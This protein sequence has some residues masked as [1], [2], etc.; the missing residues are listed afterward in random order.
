[1]S[2]SSV[3]TTS[4]D[5]AK[6]YLAEHA[7]G[8]N[9]VLGEFWHEKREQ[10]QDFPDII[11]GAFD[12]YDLLT[13]DGKK[14]RAGLVCLGHDV[15]RRDDSPRSLVA[16][17]ILRAA[18]SVEILHNAFLIHDDIVDRADLRRNKPTVHRRYA[19]R[20]RPHFATE[21]AALSYGRAVA[22]NFGDKGQ[23]LAQELLVSSGF[24]EG[25]LLAAIRL[26]SKV[27]AET[28]AGQLLD[29]ADVRLADLTE[30]QVLQ[31]HE[32]KTAHYTIMLPLLMGA[33][34]AGAQALVLEAMR[35]FAIPVGI[36]FQVQ[37]DILGLYGDQEILGKPVDSDLKEGKKTLLFVH[38]YAS[39]EG[40]DRAFLD[41]V[42]G[43]PELTDG[44]LDRVRAI[45]RNCGALA[46]SEAMA[47]EMVERG[48]ARIEAVTCEPRWTRVLS[49]L[50]DYLIL[51]RY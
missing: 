9:R 7:A 29:V 51:R 2:R 47:R 17:G 43:N 16:D 12:A 49:G 48:R 18:G 19:E 39:C 26:L 30:E 41:R 24:P 50:A 13:S 5:E 4:L 3:D 25:V 44:D 27:T 10:W 37:D 23:A 15:V 14:I 42:H 34:L 6:R 36:A 45:V 40:E 11:S 20:F 38:T 33:T 46:R 8:V 22:L 1:M 28:V 21:A 32:Y 35:G 31:I